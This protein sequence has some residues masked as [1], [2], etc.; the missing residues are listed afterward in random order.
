MTSLIQQIINNRDVS[1]TTPSIS[2]NMREMLRER[3]RQIS[4][5]SNLMA[6][7]RNR[8]YVTSAEDIER[9]ID[10]DLA[11]RKEQ[12]MAAANRLISNS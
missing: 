9:V 2:D 6:L 8:T 7:I 10:R 11:W 4:W 1:N 5:D 3:E 12:L